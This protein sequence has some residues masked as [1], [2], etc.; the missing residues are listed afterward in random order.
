MY[1]GVSS[2]KFI[3][4]FTLKEKKFYSPSTFAR[5]SDNDEDERSGQENEWT[6]IHFDIQYFSLSH[7]LI[8]LTFL[9][10]VYYRL[11][12]RLLDIH[13]SS[14]TNFYTIHLDTLWLSLIHFKIW[15]MNDGTKDTSIRLT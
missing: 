6:N 4:L 5:S 8:L 13:I 10:C 1:C 9:I 14:K 3:T 15:Q 7:I 12:Q 2:A 11:V